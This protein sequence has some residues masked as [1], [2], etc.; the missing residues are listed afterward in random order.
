MSKDNLDGKESTTEQQLEY[1]SPKNVLDVI[2]DEA[3]VVKPGSLA[4]LSE[5]E[6]QK[7][8]AS[9][10]RKCDIIVMPTLLIMYILNYLDRQNIAA[11][12][13]ATL[14]KDLHLT[15]VQYQTCVSM[16]FV[17]YILMQVPSNLI[18]QR[19]DRPALYLCIAMVVWGAVSAATAAAK[20]YPS[21]VAC[22]FIL[23]FVEAP[24]FPGCLFFMSLFYTRSQYAKRLAILQ[25]GSQMG[26]AFGGLFAIV[27]LKLEG[28]HGIAGWRW[29]FIVEGVVTIGVGLIAATYLPNGPQSFRWLTP[30]EKEYI[31]W[32]VRSDQKAEDDKETSAWDAVR[33]M[34]SD[35]KLWML[36]FISYCTQILGSVNNF[37]PSVVATLGYSRNITYLLVAPPYVLGCLVMLTNSW[38]SDRTHERSF[39]VAIP[40][41]FAAIACAIAI[42]TT[43]IGPRY[44]AMMI[45]PASYYGAQNVSFS[46]LSNTMAQPAAKRAASM[47][48]VNCFG[49][50]AN[51]WTSYTY[52][53]APRYFPAF[54]TCLVAA[55]LGFTLTIITRFYL[56]QKN[57]EMDR[58]DISARG[59]PTAEQ[60]AAGF[61]YYL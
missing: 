56:R 7:L 46:W 2:V 3:I 5:E 54:A 13:L 52:R 55:C 61:R 45:L 20:D 25:C 41:V 10:T 28:A 44:F 33:M 17:G 36:N 31:A 47:A 37:F 15:A 22:R 30:L 32:N 53:G 14:V 60:V 24:F 29:L 8:G 42:S 43:H 27:I 50:T 59:A 4:N 48:F 18:V 6:Y 57:Q 38:H 16:L 40:F 21:L 51:I 23:G 19:I 1:G 49:A 34:F 11:A 58:G 39:H 12:K 35:P 9:A 26:T